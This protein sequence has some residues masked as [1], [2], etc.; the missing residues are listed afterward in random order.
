V[1]DGVMVALVGYFFEVIVLA[2]ES[3]ESTSVG[4][5]FLAEEAP[6][7]FERNPWQGQERQVD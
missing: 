6:A 7:F 5:L 1:L 2:R 3:R 4:Y